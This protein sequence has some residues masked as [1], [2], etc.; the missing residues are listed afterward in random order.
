[1]L[2][3]VEESPDASKTTVSAADNQTVFDPCCFKRNTDGEYGRVRFLL[4]EGPAL[5]GAISTIC[6]F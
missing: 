6:L 1:M 4:R 2:I 3:G 5:R